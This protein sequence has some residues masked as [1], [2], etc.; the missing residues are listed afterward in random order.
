MQK[1]VFDFQTG[2]AGASWCLLPSLQNLFGDDKQQL[3][4]GVHRLRSGCLP[5]WF[6]AVHVASTPT[7]NGWIITGDPATPQRFEPAVSRV[8]RLNGWHYQSSIILELIFSRAWG[9]LVLNVAHLL[10]RKFACQDA[11]TLLF[12]IKKIFYSI[13]PQMF[14][15]EIAILFIYYLFSWFIRFNRLCNEKV[16]LCL[17]LFFFP[18]LL[19][20]HWRWALDSSQKLDFLGLEYFRG[21]Q[22]NYEER[23]KNQPHAR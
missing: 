21:W 13:Y 17:M 2:H 9:C 19:C 20:P 23:G 14:L 4:N 3:W 1:L 11:I 8:W 5:R 22:H 15:Q 7:T 6:F 18:F 12:N 16:F 10:R